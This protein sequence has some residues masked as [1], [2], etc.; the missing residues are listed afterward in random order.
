MP[1]QGEEQ[2]AAIKD[3]LIRGNGSNITNPTFVVR[4]LGFPDHTAIHEAVRSIV[5][6][7]AAWCVYVM[8]K[9]HG[10]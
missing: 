10:G 9:Q 1:M 3:K 5:A 4:D 8:G 7:Y 2:V 6:E